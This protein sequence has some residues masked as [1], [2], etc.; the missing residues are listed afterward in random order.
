VKRFQ[1]GMRVQATREAVR[2]LGYKP[3]TQGLVTSTPQR[4]LYVNVRRDGLRASSHYHRDFWRI[5]EGH[6]GSP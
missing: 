2:R 6:G 5:V 1:K 4:D 3:G